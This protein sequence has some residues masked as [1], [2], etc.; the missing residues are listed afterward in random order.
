[1]IHPLLNEIDVEEIIK[2]MNY[3]LWVMG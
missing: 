3:G 1:L 2:I